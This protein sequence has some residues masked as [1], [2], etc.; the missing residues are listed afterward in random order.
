MSKYNGWNNYETWRVNMEFGLCDDAE[1]FK[2]WS[3]ESL[4]EYVEEILEQQAS[5]IALDYALAFVSDVDWHEIAE[6]IEKVNG[7]DGAA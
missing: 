6:A 5:G 3:A 2:D 1:N 4:K 7:E